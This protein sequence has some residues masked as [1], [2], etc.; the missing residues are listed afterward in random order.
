MAAHRR[1]CGPFSTT[2]RQV[3]SDNQ[4]PGRVKRAYARAALA[5]RATRT[6]RRPK[7]PP[8][9]RSPS[10]RWRRRHRAGSSPDS[11]ANTPTAA[12]APTNW[13]TM[14]GGA[15]AGAIPAKVSD[16]ARATVTAGLAKAVEAVNQ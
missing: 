9:R 13:A 11:Q 1:R 16:R 8:A 15:E 7:V 4:A 12:A 5:S 6:N 2:P 14:K 10:R 3:R